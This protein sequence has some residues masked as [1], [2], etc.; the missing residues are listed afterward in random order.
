MKIHVYKRSKQN[1]SLVRL[2]FQQGGVLETVAKSDCCCLLSKR[3]KTPTTDLDKLQFLGLRF[4]VS[5][6]KN[7]VFPRL[8]FATDTAFFHTISGEISPFHSL[9]CMG[10]IPSTI[11]CRIARSF[12]PRG[13]V[14][15]LKENLLSYSSTPSLRDLKTVLC[16]PGCSN[17][18]THAERKQLSSRHRRA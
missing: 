8:V 9:G 18:P 2:V 6:K 11:F 15:F 4:I 10:V 7:G 1:I 14:P 16:S 13:P 3:N 17:H 12:L 5:R